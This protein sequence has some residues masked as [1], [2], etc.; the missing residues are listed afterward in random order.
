MIEGKTE[1][2]TAEIEAPLTETPIVASENTETGV[3]VVTTEAPIDKGFTE[4]DFLNFVKSKGKEINSFD[5][6]FAE[7]EPIIKEINPYEDILDDEDKRYLA[8]KKETRRSRKDFEALNKDYDQV[9]SLTLAR[10]RARTES[11]KTLTDEQVDAYLERKLGIDLSESELDDYSTI[12][13]AAY[14][15]SIREQYKAEQEKYKQPLAPKEPT[16]PD[17]LVQLNN[18]TTMKKADYEAMVVQH[19]KHIEKAVASVDS[20]ADASFKFTFDDNGTKRDLTYSYEN[21]PEDKQRL[22]S[23]V[24]DINGYMERKFGVGDN[25]DHVAFNRNAIWMDE[26]YREKAIPIMLEAARA[27][28]IEEMM[29]VQNNVN[30][31]R[32][33]LPKSTGEARIVPINQLFNRY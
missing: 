27:E 10:E 12:E 1:N 32:N 18:G 8:Y 25:F 7:K 3:E 21:S 16:L 6:L 26:S 2:Q 28:A 20:V 31:D 30:F 13:L 4:E 23:M 22:V 24:G 33:P 17:D 15:K 9:D 11:G 5:E 14:T 19:Q 29:K